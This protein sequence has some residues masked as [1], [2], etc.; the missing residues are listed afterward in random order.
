MTAR[1]NVFA[2]STLSKCITT[3]PDKPYAI[4]YLTVF[5]FED[6]RVAQNSGVSGAEPEKK[7]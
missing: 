7:K 1:D 3:G 2:Q 5:Y 4:C 6:S